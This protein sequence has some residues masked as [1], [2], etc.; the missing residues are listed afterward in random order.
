[1][2]VTGKRASTSICAACRI[3]RLRQ[4]RISG[5]IEVIVFVCK[6]KFLLKQSLAK[7]QLLAWNLRRGNKKRATPKNPSPGKTE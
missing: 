2:H 6:E 4:L 5:L 7:I 3:G 1:M